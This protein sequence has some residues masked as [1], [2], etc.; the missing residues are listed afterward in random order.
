MSNNE[1]I[2]IMIGSSFG[3]AFVL[4]NVG[5][6][7]NGLALAVRGI[8]ILAFIGLVI[9]LVRM[10]VKAT[11]TEAPE[12]GGGMFARRYWMVVAGEIVVGAAGVVI[13]N[14]GLGWSAAT[15][16]WIALV[17]G[18]HFLLLAR[19]WQM[20]EI[21]A[22]GGAIALCGAAGM[23]LAALGVS[24]STVRLV[25]GALSGCFLLVGGWM[26]VRPASRT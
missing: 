8:A 24:E 20:P 19:V 4:A 3:L 6:L 15:V 12:A 2:G 7:P 5:G 18:G 14:A 1:R 25:S 9:R 11:P 10:P 26:G 21:T 22:V 13:I 17:V 16:P 23:V